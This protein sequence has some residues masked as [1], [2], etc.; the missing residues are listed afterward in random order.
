[1]LFFVHLFQLYAVSERLKQPC[2]PL[3]II[4]QRHD[5]SHVLD[6]C[7]QLKCIKIEGSYNKYEASNIIPNELKFELSAFK[8]L[9]TLMLFNVSL[10]NIYGLGTVKETVTAIS[11]KQCKA[12]SLG[13]ILLCDELHKSVECIT[14]E[15][16]WH[17][18]VEADLSQNSISEFSKCFLFF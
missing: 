13:D 17:K 7:S 14:D 5:F 11:V 3:E 12:N 6:F 1:M 8:V 18:L 9:E 10:S 4:D 16:K 15:K 2:P